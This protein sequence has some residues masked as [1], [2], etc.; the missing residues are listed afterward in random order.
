MTKAIILCDA[1]TLISRD[2]GVGRLPLGSPSSS[3][4]G[5]G[6]ERAAGAG[7]GRGGGGG[8]DGEDGGVY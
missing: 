1:P 5:T 3:A 8:H 4:A 7:R 2:S 6:A